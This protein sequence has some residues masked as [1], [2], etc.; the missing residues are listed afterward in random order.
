MCKYN[1]NGQGQKAYLG[2]GEG[3]GQLGSRNEMKVGMINSCLSCLVDR[4]LIFIL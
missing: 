2:E 4:D 1:S 3:G